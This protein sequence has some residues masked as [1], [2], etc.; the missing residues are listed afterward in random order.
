[1]L[2]IIEIMLTISAWKKGWKGW[3]AL[4]WAILFLTVMAVA[5][6]AGSEEAAF[7]IGLVGDILLI[8]VLGVMAAT[9]HGPQ[10]VQSMPSQS[11]REP[12]PTTVV[13]KAENH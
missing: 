1:M 4:P 2:L 9:A 5:G 6:E 12:L 11:E 13:N 10:T 7:G 3:V 8:V